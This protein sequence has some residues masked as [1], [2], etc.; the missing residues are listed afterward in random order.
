MGT[1]GE[2]TM[3]YG[4]EL[5]ERKDFMLQVNLGIEKRG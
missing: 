3:A 4:D 2:E 5:T 1:F